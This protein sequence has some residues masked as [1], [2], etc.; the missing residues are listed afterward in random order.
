MI[1]EFIIF[2]QIYSTST[3]VLDIQ[4]NI[5]CISRS[6]YVKR[7]TNFYLNSD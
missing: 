5:D 1:S 4:E 7:L 2:S 6:Q 3:I